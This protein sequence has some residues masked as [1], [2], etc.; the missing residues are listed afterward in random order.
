MEY[1]QHI[2]HA[3]SNHLHPFSGA[4][5][6]IRESGCSSSSHGVNP[7]CSAASSPASSDPTCPPSS[8]SF[9]DMGKGTQGKGGYNH[10]VQSS[11]LRRGRNTSRGIPQIVQHARESGSRFW[12]TLIHP[13]ILPFLDKAKYP[14]TDS[15]SS[16]TAQF[17]DLDASASSKEL[18][19]R[20]APY[21]YPRRMGRELGDFDATAQEASFCNPS[22]LPIEPCPDVSKHR[23]KFIA[24]P[25][26]TGKLQDVCDGVGE[27][28][29]ASI[30]SNEIKTWKKRHNLAPKV[31]MDTIT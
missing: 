30:D 1:S 10:Q 25:R 29:G 11:S 6:P 22:E 2:N 18:P 20:P 5:T 13:S 19:P 28:D 21:F 7:S 14:A 17:A 24:I 9:I 15:I 23:S 16:I 3:T 27:K 8:A 12:R 4:S 26:K 31:C